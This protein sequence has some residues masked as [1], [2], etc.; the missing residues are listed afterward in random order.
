MDKRKHI[1]N[2]LSIHWFR[3]GH[4][5]TPNKP[6]ELPTKIFYIHS[7]RSFFQTLTTLV[8]RYNNIQAAA[9]KHLADALRSN[10]VIYSH[11]PFFHYRLLRSSQTLTTLYLCNNS[12][13]TA[14]AK[15]LADV[16]ATNQVSRCLYPSSILYFLIHHRHSPHSVFNTTVFKLQERNI[17]LMH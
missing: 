6:S 13:S 10:G 14:G 7:R 9:A 2:Q 15:H 4:V 16:L 11:S 1:P 17:L 3:T 12:I 8:L 5:C